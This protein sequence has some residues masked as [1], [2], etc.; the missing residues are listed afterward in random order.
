MARAP[1]WAQRV[2]AE[3]VVRLAQEPSR[4]A[5][6]YLVEDLPFAVRL[7]AGAAARRRARH[8]VPT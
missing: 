2:G 5:R 8:R 6:R 3:W 1:G 4:L 7:L